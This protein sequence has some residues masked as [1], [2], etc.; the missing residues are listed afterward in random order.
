[1]RHAHLL[2]EELLELLK[3]CRSLLHWLAVQSDPVRSL[4]HST[5]ER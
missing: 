4:E 1:M 3:G 5:V 2:G